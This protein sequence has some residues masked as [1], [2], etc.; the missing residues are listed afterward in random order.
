MQYEHL[1]IWYMLTIDENIA[2]ILLSYRGWDQFRSIQASL[3]QTY[4]IVGQ[5]L[6]GLGTI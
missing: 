5:I 1:R 4:D 6:T 2:A 3:Q